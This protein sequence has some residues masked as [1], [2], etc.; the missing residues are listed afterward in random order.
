MRPTIGTAIGSISWPGAPP[1]GASVAVS[2][3]ILHLGEI[4]IWR[5]EMM[6]M[7]RT[8]Q[9]TTMLPT[10]EPNLSIVLECNN[11]GQITATCLI[12]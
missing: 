9:G 2:G 4:E 12:I 7:H 1:R 3:P 8:L 5:K 10:L 6:E 11:L